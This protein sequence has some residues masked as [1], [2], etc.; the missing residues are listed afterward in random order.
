DA[1]VESLQEVDVVV[2]VHDASSRAGKG[3]EYLSRL[4]SDATVPVILVLN[5]IDLV[6]KPR[7][8]PVIDQLRRW[9]DF[10][11]ILPLSAA[12]GDGVDR[13]ERLLL[14]RMPEG[15]ALYPDDFITDQPQR[16]LAAET[17]REKVLQ[18]TRAEL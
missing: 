11:D 10:A 15:E 4:L 18:H 1:A 7:L 14:E 13:L 16:T 9:H 6:S 5:K 12:T 2:L 8:L 17:V 3:D